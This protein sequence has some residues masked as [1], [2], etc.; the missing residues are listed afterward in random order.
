[1]PELR[2]GL[3]LAP[4]EQLG[5]VSADHTRQQH[6]G[7]ARAA[8]RRIRQADHPRQH[9]RHLDDGDGVLAPEG[10]LAAQPHDEVERLVGHL[11]EW[12]R[13]VQPHRHQQRA[14]LALEEVVDPAPLRLV[15]VVVVQDL[16]ALAASACRH[17]L[18]VEDSG[19]ARRSAAWA[20]AATEARSRVRDA[21]APGWRTASM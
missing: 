8:L 7:L 10:I 13:R 16:D 12:V 9:A 3:D 1:M 11:R 2:E 4:R 6:E 19:T 14:H 20:S 18:V 17:H 15:A 5:Q 21:R